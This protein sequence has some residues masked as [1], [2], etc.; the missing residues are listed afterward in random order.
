MKSKPVFQRKYCKV[1]NQFNDK[2]KMKFLAGRLGLFKALGTGIGKVGFLGIDVLNN[3]RGKPLV[4]KSPFNGNT[5]ITI[6]H[7]NTI[8][9]A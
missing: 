5:F 6:K 8:V 2:R 9:A 1:F 4:T 3:K 7:P